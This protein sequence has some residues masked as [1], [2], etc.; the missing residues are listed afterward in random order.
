[1]SRTQD[2]LYPAQIYDYDTFWCAK[3]QMF[4]SHESAPPPP[5]LLW[6]MTPG[7]SS[8]SSRENV[9]IRGFGAH[10]RITSRVLICAQSWQTHSKV[11]FLGCGAPRVRITAINEPLVHG[12]ACSVAG[13]HAQVFCFVFCVSEWMFVGALRHPESLCARGTQTIFKK[14]IELE[15]TP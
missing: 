8:V 10:L 9:S 14:K 1:M 7:L 6:L 4:S 13:L 12:I 11:L 15:L 3:T 5:P 2:H